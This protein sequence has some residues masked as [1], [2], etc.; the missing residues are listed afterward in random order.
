VF[1]QAALGMLLYPGQAQLAAL[2]LLLAV[3]VMAATCRLQK[4]I[5]LD[6]L[7]LALAWAIL[8]SGSIN[9]LIAIQ[10][11][12]DIHTVFDSVVARSDS[13][14]P[15]GNL[16]QPN[17]FAAHQALALAALLFMAARQR[18]HLLVTLTIGGL[19]LAGLAL[20]GSR[21]GWLY[22]G[23]VL[24]MA[25]LHQRK[26]NSADARRLLHYAALTLPVFFLAQY[27]LTLLEPAT[28]T[29]NSRLQGYSGGA[30]G[31]RAAMW[32]DAWQAFLSTPLT[33]V[34][35]QRLAWQHFHLQAE[36]PNPLFS[37]FEDNHL[38]NAH[39]IVFQLLAEF[40]IGGAI[41]L[42]IAAWWLF[43]A[44]RGMQN[45]E[46]W[47]VLA[48]LAIVALH[49][50][51]EYPLHYM[52]FLLVAAVLLALA[53]QSPVRLNPSRGIAPLVTAMSI[54]LGGGILA[55]MFANYQSLEEVHERARGGRISLDL[56]TQL[57]LVKAERGKF[58]TP[59]VHDFVNGIK[60]SIGEPDSWEPLRNISE[61]ATQH[62]T[63][64]T[65]VYRHILLLALNGETVETK[66]YL[67]LAVRAYPRHLAVLKKQVA[68]MRHT[69]PDH[70][71]LRQLEEML[72]K[73]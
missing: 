5:G 37:R 21:S 64:A 46:H 71:G 15:F 22:L 55:L 17:H 54:L 1:L 38:E 23:A 45:P 62:R 72:A 12:W 53:D 13:A 61:S 59:E 24:V 67:S 14:R 65:Y 25:Y 4:D 69:R 60:V 73:T 32:L 8:I 30:I 2:Y 7:V 29:A 70:A 11:Q 20:S 19:L 48:M 34:G 68:E 49:S 27:G 58:L 31:V 41:L 36:S 33:G 43:K 28:I 39:N 47:L 3:L 9:A 51:L 10:Q 66:R 52:H 18:L 16:S 6:R 56:S 35:Y 26:S 40:G 63:K 57:L 44:Y 42:V 50:L